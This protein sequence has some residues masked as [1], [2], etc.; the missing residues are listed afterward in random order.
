MAAQAR[1]EVV[2][3]QAFVEAVRRDLAAKGAQLTEETV[4]VKLTGTCGLEDFRH[5]GP[6]LRE[7]SAG[8]GT[9]S[10]VVQGAPP[11]PDPEDST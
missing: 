8:S 7:L 11:V 4:L 6:R 5:Y 1:L 2:V 3:P 9:Y 10:A